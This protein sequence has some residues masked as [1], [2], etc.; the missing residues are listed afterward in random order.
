MILFSAAFFLINLN[1]QK[2]PQFL[3]KALGKT[4][5]TIDQYQSCL[6]LE[7][8]LKRLC[9]SAFMVILNIIAFFTHF[10][11]ALGKSVQLIMHWYKLLNQSVTQL[12][13]MSLAVVFLLNQYGVR[14]KAY[15]WFQSYLSN[16][17]LYLYVSMVINLILSQSLVEYFSDPFLDPC[18]FCYI[19]LYPTPRNCLVSTYLLMTLIYIVQE[20][21]LII[22][23]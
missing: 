13:A 12:T 9:L 14:G 21:T 22:L 19:L 2:L 4:K 8:F 11:L 18:C 16:R 20:K 15:D 3:R 23:N 10:N 17:E 6:F 1:W 7:K 5:L